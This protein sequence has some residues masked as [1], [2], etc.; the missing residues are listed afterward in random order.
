MLMQD[1]GYYT[2]TASSRSQVLKDRVC[3]TVLG[4]YL[5]TGK[6]YFTFFFVGKPEIKTI[7]LGTQQF[8]ISIL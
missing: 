5:L 1:A 8:C 4:N 7:V 2:C 3:V 6:S